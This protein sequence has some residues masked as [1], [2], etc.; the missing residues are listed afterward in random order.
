[1]IK[2]KRVLNTMKS[3]LTIVSC[4]LIATLIL[5]CNVSLSSADEGIPVGTRNADG[6]I[7]YG[8]VVYSHEDIKYAWDISETIGGGKIFAYY[9]RDDGDASKYDGGT[10]IIMDVDPSADPSTQ[11]D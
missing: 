7:T 5:V 8:G 4:M 11:I 2:T 9:F 6:D 3:K 1:M 10:V